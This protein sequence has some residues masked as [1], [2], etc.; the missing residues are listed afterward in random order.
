MAGRASTLPTQ[1]NDGQV[2]PAAEGLARRAAQAGGAEPRALGQ[3]PG[4][5]EGD[6]DE[7]V[8]RV[9]ALGNGGDDEAGG[10]FGG[11]VL[12]RMDGGVDTALQERGLDLLG[13]KA[14][15]ADLG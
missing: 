11:H 12:E 9:L 7:D 8:S 4:A 1:R 13:E 15:A 6:A 2:G 5:G 10:S 3:V 14:L